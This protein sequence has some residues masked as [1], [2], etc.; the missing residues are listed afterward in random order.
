MGDT[1]SN[2]SQSGQWVDVDIDTSVAHAARIYD[3]MLGGTTNFEADRQASHA[4]AALVPGGH[5]TVTAG[6]RAN[7][8][9]LGRAVQYLAAEAGIRQFLDVGSGIPVGDNVHDV[10]Q[11]AAPESRIVYVDYDPIVLA[12]S[13]TLLTSTPEG[14]TV[15]I[16]EDLRHTDQVLEQAAATLDFSRPVG[17][18]MVAIMHFF[19]DDED[20][21]GVVRRL[22]EAVPPGSYL[23]L[24]HLARDIYDLDPTYERLN[25]ATR[26]TFV[27]RTHAEVVRFFDGLDVLDPGV[28][29]VDQWRQQPDHVPHEGQMLPL[30]GAVARK[31]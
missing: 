13:H 25:A 15:Y 4:A 8:A 20:P 27:L 16:Q 10:A 11:G 29:L 18:I 3:Y 12:H 7:R 14:K 2:G 22:V 31:P 28:V 9:F 1:F 19:V 26:E 24:S 23:V 17:V 30:Y 6:L 21:Y 5:E